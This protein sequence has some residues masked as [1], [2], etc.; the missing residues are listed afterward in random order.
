MAASENRQVDRAAI[1]RAIRSAEQSS[2]VEFSVF[3]G[4]AVGEPRDY[5]ARLHA[6][7][8]AP[9]RSI[10]ILVDPTARAVEVVTGEDVR[11]V[12]S[13]RE[14]EHVVQAM[15]PELA[16]GDLTGA[17]VRGIPQLAEHARAPRTL[18]G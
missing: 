4:R 7:L 2:R 16:A 3:V 1:D 11:R 13:D 6:S 18:H 17:L 9:A 15:T 5:A 12:L 8:V 10:M 14:V